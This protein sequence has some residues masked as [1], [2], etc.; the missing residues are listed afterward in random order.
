MSLSSSFQRPVIQSGETTWCWRKPELQPEGDSAECGVLSA[1]L[2]DFTMKQRR[3]SHALAVGVCV[4]VVR[5]S[6]CRHPPIFPC[7]GCDN[8]FFEQITSD[9]FVQLPLRKMALLCGLECHH[10]QEAE[11]EEI[12]TMR[13]DKLLMCSAICVYV[14]ALLCVCFFS[15]TS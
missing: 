15:F 5:S 8:C 6:H 1:A 10:Y 12:N 13:S 9:S 7:V 3:P 2:P 4:S 11:S 14:V